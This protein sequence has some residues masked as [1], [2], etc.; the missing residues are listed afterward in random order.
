MI[1]ILIQA[2]GFIIVIVIG[3]LLKTKGVCKREHGQFLSTIIMNITLPCSLLSSINNL[4]LTP[5]L[6]LALLFGFL[7][8]VITNIGGYLTSKGEKP[9]DRALAMINTS[10]Y[11]IGTFTLPF[12][13]AFFASDAIAYVCMFDTGN[14]LMCLGGTFTAASAVV[15]DQDKPSFHSIIKKLFSSIPFCTYIVLFFLSLFHISIPDFILTL[16]AT[17]KNANA[18]LAMLMIGIMLEIKL[19]F[20]QIKKIQKILLTRYSISIILSL[21][22]YFVLPLDQLI[23]K[24][25]V[26]CLFAPVSAVAPVFSAKL[27][28]RS[29]VPAAVNSLSIL[30]S[31]IILTSLIL[32]FA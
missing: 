22:I 25:V 17:A 21:I 32:L 12:V 24:M 13:Q 29:P 16:T 14:A 7:G 6:L 3:F 30:I 28:S 26:I 11:N 31:I 9:M 27:G 2:L 15:S 20:S 5:L 19:D 10:G 1:D 23:K 8:N 18:F 4:E